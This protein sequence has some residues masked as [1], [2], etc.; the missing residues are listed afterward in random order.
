MEQFFIAIFGLTALWL[1]LGKDDNLRK[2]SPI[3]GLLGQP[4]WMYFA[5]RNGGWGILILTFFYTLVYI[6]GFIV[7]W[8]YEDII[9]SFLK[10][11][12]RGF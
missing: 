6:R 12:F 11:N 10:N 5:I 8:G 3:C 2:W 1:A 4:F 7:Q 9:K